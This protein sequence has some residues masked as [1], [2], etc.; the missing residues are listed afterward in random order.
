[1]TEAARQLLE[2]AREAALKVIEK[3]DSKPAPYTTPEWFEDVGDF[4]TLSGYRQA[5]KSFLLGELNKR[6]HV[7][8]SNGKHVMYSKNNGQ[9]LWLFKDNPSL[10]VNILVA[11]KFNGVFV[12][13]A[14]SLTRQKTPKGKISLVGGGRFRIQAVLEDCMMMLPFEMFKETRLDINSLEM[15]DRGDSETVQ[16]KRA[17]GRRLENQHFMGAM[18]FKIK[19]RARSSE[20]HYNGKAQYFLF[21]I[22]RNDLKLKNLNFFLSRL[23][24]PVVSIDDAYASLKPK[25]V[26]DAERFLK[27]PVQR[28]GEWFFIP[29]TGEFEK[30]KGVTSSFHVGSRGMRANLQSK[31]NRPHYVEWLSEEDYVKGLVT[32][33][34][35]EHEPIELE[36]WCKPVPN[37]AVESFKISGAID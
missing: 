27:H 30:K 6:V 15:I 25:E 5:V 29:V 20:L 37:T 14:S 32:H 35:H 28:Q 17:G 23:G 3:L 33:G 16:V 18:V 12:G 11:K 10:K 7:K 26:S 13:N 34:G 1:M 22:D 9:E 21:D 8:A 24:R 2:D 19:A 4:K 31:G 36:T